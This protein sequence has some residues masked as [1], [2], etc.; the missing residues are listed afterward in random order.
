MVGRVHETMF[1]AFFVSSGASKLMQT[2]EEIS[3]EPLGGHVKA[4]FECSFKGIASQGEVR[5]DGVGG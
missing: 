5:C 4:A 2:C 1:V 3:V